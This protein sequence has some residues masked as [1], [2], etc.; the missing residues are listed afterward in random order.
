LLKTF[1]QTPTYSYVAKKFNTTVKVIRKYCVDN[2]L[3][4]DIND[5]RDKQGLK[6]LVNKL[7]YL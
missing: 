2:N 5:I 6:P 7:A 1:Q 4:N 3:I